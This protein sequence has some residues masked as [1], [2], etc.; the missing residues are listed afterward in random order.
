MHGYAPS[1][2]LERGGGDL[3]EGTIWQYLKTRRKTLF[4]I[5]N[6]AEIQTKC[7]K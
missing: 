4:W 2:H 6:L 7:L 3:S 1:T 5:E